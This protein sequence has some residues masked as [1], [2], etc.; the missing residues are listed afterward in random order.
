MSKSDEILIAIKAQDKQFQTEIKKVQ[1]SLKNLGTTADKAGKAGATG[2]GSFT[3]KITSLSTL[4]KGFMGLQIIGFFKDIG[5]DSF[6]DKEN[7][8]AILRDS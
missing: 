3:S 5:A 7:Y 4:V 6:T 2:I 1:K 8:F